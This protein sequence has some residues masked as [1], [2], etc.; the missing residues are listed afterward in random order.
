MMR[1]FDT[2]PR[3]DLRKKNSFDDVVRFSSI[4]IQAC[5]VIFAVAL[6]L[7]FSVMSVVMTPNPYII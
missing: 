5:M 1:N 4:N 3:A 6:I 2:T 7:L